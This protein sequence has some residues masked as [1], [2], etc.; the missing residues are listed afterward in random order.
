MEQVAFTEL[1]WM[2]TTSRED[3]CAI[4]IRIRLCDLIDPDVLRNAVDTTMRR[5]PYFCVELQ[6]RDGQYIFAE[7]QRPVV[8]AN[9]PHGV[10]LNS[11]QSNFHMI[12]FSWWDSWMML[13]VF[14]GITDGTGAYEV[15]RTLMHYYCSER[16]QVALSEK[17]VRLLGGRGSA[18]GVGRPRVWQ[19]GPP[20]A[21]AR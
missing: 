11:K 4:R 9:S 7:N 10:E 1:R 19:G 2:Y 8:I 20:G 13:D 5:Y 21:F 18:G 17:G 3:P 16:Y 15:I 14:H 6:E 12:A